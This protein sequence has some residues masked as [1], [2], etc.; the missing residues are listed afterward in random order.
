L[1]WRL[2]WL[3]FPA[4]VLDVLWDHSLCRMKHLAELGEDSKGDSPGE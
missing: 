3:I 1:G 4:F 2:G